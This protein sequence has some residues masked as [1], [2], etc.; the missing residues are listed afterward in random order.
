MILPKRVFVS[1]LAVASMLTQASAS[2]NFISGNITA[3]A[4]WSGTNLLTGTVVIQSN[5]VV[6]IDPGARILMNTAAVL[7]IEGQLLAN[8]T[9][10]QPITFTR[11]TTTTNWGRLIFVRAQP[12]RLSHCVVEFANS[13]GDHQSYYPTDC[14]NPAPGARTYREAVVSLGTHLDIEGCTFQNLPF[15]TGSRDGDAIAIIA[16]D[17]DFSGP[18]SAHIRNCRFISIGQGIHS[19][20][21]PLLVEHCTFSDKRGDNDDID[22]YGESTPAP[23]IRYN[24]FLAGHEDKINPTRC[25][26]IIYGNFISG[27]DD[28]GV[29][30]RDKCNPIVFNNI[31][32]NFTAA[33]ISVQ[34]QCDALI[35]NNT[36]VNSGRGVRM[37][38]HTGRHGPPYCLFPG[39]GKATLVNNIIWNTPSGAV[40]ME[41]SSFLPHPE[42]TITH[43][44][45]QNGIVTNNANCVINWGPG[46]INANPQFVN[47][48]RLG[49]TS[50]CIDAG[51]NALSL[52]ST[53]WS[54]S[55]TNDLDGLARPLDGN[56]DSLARFDIGAY[57]V[58]LASAD[59]NGDGI[60]DGWTQRFGL[61]PT[62]PS[63]A[64]GNPDND[65]HTT[66][67]EWIADTDPTDPLSYLR[68]ESILNLPPATV[69]F[70]SSS[71]RTYTLRHATDVAGP[72]LPV[73]GR[74]NIPGTGG[75]QTFNDPNAAPASFYRIEVKLP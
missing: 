16:D 13:V 32:S 71:N 50:P 38:D 52:V 37:F 63:V 1:W 12:S 10:N 4:T 65:P 9:S 39:N 72:F 64:A 53:N 75:T 66:L 46:N 33:A 36:I 61:N 69:Q 21:S 19:R 3:N 58:I 68:I 35:A 27:G 70:L 45:L 56:G 8:G 73:A 34:N 67:D 7:R 14:A 24:T 23:V 30:L 43:C 42:V 49:S 17:R 57:E 2:T 74:E 51:T 11:S 60:P 47:G 6:T 26:A 62:D 28:H 31:I 20:Y 5:V 25:S 59:S 15:A 41:A 55:I 18:A 54:A 29:V 48:L 40:T 44:N 22:M